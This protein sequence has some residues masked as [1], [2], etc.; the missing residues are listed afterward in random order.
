[1]DKKVLRIAFYAETNPTQLL[2]AMIGRDPAQLSPAGLVD[3]RIAFETPLSLALLK[4]DAA[5]LSLEKI[6]ARFSIDGSIS[7]VLDRRV[8]DVVTG[9]I[10]EEK[11]NLLA[12]AARFFRGL[13]IDVQ[14]ISLA[15]LATRFTTELDPENI[16]F[17]HEA[18]RFYG[19]MLNSIPLKTTFESQIGGIAGMLAG[20]GLPPEVVTIYNMVRASLSGPRRIHVQVDDLETEVSFVG[21]DIFQ[22]APELP[23]GGTE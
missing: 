21:L 15:E 5:R 16:R 9:L 10:P 20:G 18:L 2:G 12:A 14:T 17:P 1:M 22:F 4:D 3:L 7:A 19:E 13:N 8:K 11:A 6:R 23:A